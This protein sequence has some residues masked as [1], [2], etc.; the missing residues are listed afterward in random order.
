[1]RKP[2][3]TSKQQRPKSFVVGHSGPLLTE[4]ACKN[5]HQLNSKGQDKKAGE[6][7]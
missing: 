2:N 5:D 3:K 1:M 6:S 7:K 4:S